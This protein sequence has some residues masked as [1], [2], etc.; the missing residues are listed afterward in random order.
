MDAELEDV[1]RRA[2]IV[3]AGDPSTQ[4]LLEARMEAFMTSRGF[5]HQ[6]GEDLEPL[7]AWRSE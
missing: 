4:Q 6:W 3:R 5:P 7:K 2:E 1:R